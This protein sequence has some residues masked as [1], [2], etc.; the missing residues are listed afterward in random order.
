MSLCAKS[1][2]RSRLSCRTS[3]TQQTSTGVPGFRNS[4]RYRSRSEVRPAGKVRKNARGVCVAR[5]YD[6]G[7]GQFMSVDPDL[8]E[9]DQ[10]YAFADDDPVNASDPT[11]R[12][13]QG[14]EGGWP[15]SDTNPPGAIG[16][17]GRLGLSCL[18]TGRT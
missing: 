12:V 16:E 11:G 2:H 4:L 15:V 6:P 8:A 10:P 9:T 1:R 7:T 14:A 17:P 3:A 18:E 13:V 5:W